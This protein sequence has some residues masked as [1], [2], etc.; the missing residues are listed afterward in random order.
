MQRAFQW[1]KETTTEDQE[2]SA[3]CLGTA[4]HVHR[5]SAARPLDH[6]QS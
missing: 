4:R 1:G 2:K 5:S 6:L 3:A